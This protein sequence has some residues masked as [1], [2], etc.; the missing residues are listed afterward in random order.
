MANLTFTIE[1]T[2]SALITVTEVDGDLI[3]NVEL[4]SDTGTVGDLRALF[5]D[6][7][8]EAL[9]SGLSV[10]GTHV[11]GSAFRANRVTTVGGDAN[12]NG[13]VVNTLGAFDGGVAFGTPGI[14]RD[15][16]RST[17]FVLSHST[18]D[19]TL[20]LI[21]QQDF[22]VR[23]TSVGTEGGARNGSL[24]LGGEASAPPDA[25]D[26]G[27]T[28]NEDDSV[29]GNV[30]A[31]DRDADSN[32]L[33]VIAV[34]G[35]SVGS[36][37][38]V[39]SSGG[40]IGALVVAASGAYNFDPL[41]NFND[42]AVG[43]SDT[44]TVAYTIEDDTGGSDTATL[45]ITVDGTNDAPLI[46]AEA[47]DSAGASLTETNSG[48]TANGSLTASDV[49]VSDVVSASVV[50]VTHSGPVGGLSDADLLSFFQVTSGQLDTSTTTSGQLTWNFN[51][52]AEAFD[53][54]ALGETLTLHYT[55]RPDDGHSPPPIGDGVV[56]IHIEGTSDAPFEQLLPS[57]A[58]GQDA[59]TGFGIDISGDNMVVSAMGWGN[60]T[61]SVCFLER[62]PTTGLFVDVASVT[63]SDSGPNSQFGYD[64]AIDGN[65][66]IVGS[67]AKNGY[68]GAAYIFEKQS[69]GLVEVAKLTANDKASGDWFGISVA[70]NGGRAIVGA[71]FDDDNVAGSGSVYV[72]ELQGGTWTQ[73]AK[74]HASDALA[75][76]GL[77][78]AFGVDVAIS[79]NRIV[80]G[81]E[82]SN[83]FGTSSGK[84]YIFEL[85]NGSWVETKI[86]LPP[87][88]F[89][90]SL[91]YG[92]VAIDGDTVVVGAYSDTRGATDSA[93]VYEYQGG[94]WVHVAVFRTPNAIGLDGNEGSFGQSIDISGDT[95]VIGDQQTGSSVNPDPDPGIAYVYKRTN[96]AWETDPF[97]TLNASDGQAHDGFGYKIAIDGSTVVVGASRN[98]TNAGINGGSAYIFNLDRIIYYYGDDTDNFF[99][100]TKIASN[101]KVI[102]FGYDGNDTLIGAGGNDTLDGGDGNDI[103]DGGAGNDTLIGG[104]GGNI[105]RNSASNDTFIGGNRGDVSLDGNLGDYNLATAGISVTLSSTS[106]VTG[107]AS[108]GTDTLYFIDIIRG[109]E[110]AD[111]FVAT[112]SYVSQYGSSF[113]EFEGAGGDDVLIGNGNTRIGFRNALASV[114][115]DLAAGNSHSTDI[116]DSAGVGVD[117]FTGVSRA[118]G[119]AFDDFIYGASTNDQLRGEAGNDYIDGRGGFDIADYLGLF[120]PAGITAWLD[121]TNIVGTGTVIDSWGDTDTFVSIEQIRGSVHADTITGGVGNNWIEGSAG[122][123]ILDGGAGIDT[124]AYGSGLQGVTVNLL[125]GYADGGDATGDVFTNFEN[126]QGTN[127]GNDNLSGDDNPNNIQ[128]LGG[129]D[130]LFGRGGN[131]FLQGQAGDDILDGGDDFDTAVYSGNQANYIIVDNGNGSF[132]INAIVGNENS[133]TLWNIE[134]VQFADGLLLL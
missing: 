37:F 46:T 98:D 101:Q 17:Q 117:T 111:Y 39:T 4:T 34:A 128:G 81:A 21:S 31:N 90:T 33:T 95:I 76:D 83:D 62:D 122:A 133:D 2:V 59:L 60:G 66:A 105:F 63:A 3:F 41:G 28:T 132:T 71:A 96:G 108:V 102:A 61:G 78:D 50:G 115:V 103:L 64:V 69:S 119:S 87:D 97:L 106:T 26:D 110:F 116:G 65:L 36:P 126:L 118:I 75:N 130:I 23:I 123:D 51:S 42:L 104:F 79:G 54:L 114:T 19:L 131:D 125:T 70:I 94:D 29:S 14:G 16:I 18:L 100:A 68:E 56:T 134:R 47:G 35:G 32:V 127:R 113:N 12:I 84:A 109:T 30:L 88:G 45:T 9:L 85:Q 25:I 1:G 10:S 22:G 107:D 120:N 55:I 20:D 48:L 15:D 13:D 27:A 53:F 38:A 73:V 24:K 99:D 5:F 74:L 129:N 91:N 58:T 72:F 92:A 57:C 77:G 52:G 93:Y 43:E 6:V 40:R 49:D 86:L 67:P 11:T 7:N 121:V 124:L 112:S 44:V 89:L 8:D 80:V 82:S